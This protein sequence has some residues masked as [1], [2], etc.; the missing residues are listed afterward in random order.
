MQTTIKTFDNVPYTMSLERVDG[1]YV[2][3]FTCQRIFFTPQTET[4]RFDNFED[5]FQHYSNNMRY[6]N[7]VRPEPL[8]EEQFL[9]L[10]KGTLY[11]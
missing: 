1:E 6:Y 4:H 11:A 10:K 2:L 8:T 3:M 9:G 5:A 7:N